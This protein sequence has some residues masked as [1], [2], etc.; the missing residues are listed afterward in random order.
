MPPSCVTSVSCQDFSHH[1]TKD[2]FLNLLPY[3]SLLNVNLF[4]FW[5]LLLFFVI[6]VFL[7]M[8]PLLQAFNLEKW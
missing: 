2:F 8:C 7:F 1:C 3:C 4:S 6:N 5:F